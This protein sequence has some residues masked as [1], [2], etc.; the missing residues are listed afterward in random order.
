MAD[1]SEEGRDKEKRGRKQQEEV[2]TTKE[3]KSPYQTD[4]GYTTFPED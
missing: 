4:L 2:K 1:T 3:I